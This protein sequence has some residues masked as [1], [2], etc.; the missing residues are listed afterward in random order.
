MEANNQQKESQDNISPLV[1][2]SEVTAYNEKSSLKLELSSTQV[3]NVYGPND[4]ISLDKEKN[5]IAISTPETRDG[6]VIT[7]CENSDSG[8]MISI[9]SSINDISSLKGSKTEDGDNSSVKSKKR[10]SFF[11]FRRSKKDQKKEVIL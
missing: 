6:C 8:S 4:E 9:S 1:A 5:I 7:P 10:R 3:E 2:E 11:N